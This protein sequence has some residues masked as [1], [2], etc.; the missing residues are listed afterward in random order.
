M[1][2]YGRGES[3]TWVVYDSPKGTDHTVGPY[4]IPEN[5]VD[6]W[7]VSTCTRMQWCATSCWPLGVKGGRRGQ[8]FSHTCLTSQF[9]PLALHS[10]LCSSLQS[11]TA[12]PYFPG[13]AL[14]LG[15][16]VPYMCVHRALRSLPRMASSISNTGKTAAKCRTTSHR[17]HI[18]DDTS[19][20]SLASPRN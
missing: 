4:A 1:L 8:S 11:S 20:A 3:G 12:H 19:K 18:K 17:S 2:Q 10:T 15:L 5:A 6:V 7:P 13:L 16:V 14:S 9:V